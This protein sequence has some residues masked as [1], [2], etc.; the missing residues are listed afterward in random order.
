MAITQENMKKLSP[1]ELCSQLIDA[2]GDS[3]SGLVLDSLEEQ[4]VSGASFL[5]LCD[6]DLYEVASL[7]G[8]RVTLRNYIDGFKIST[9]VHVH[10]LLKV[11]NIDFPTI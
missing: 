5:D 8:D 7:P 6:E 11:D 2:L 3:I 10:A 4:R 9:K 1:S